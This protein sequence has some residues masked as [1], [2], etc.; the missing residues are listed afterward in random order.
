MCWNM[1][2]WH[3]HHVRNWHIVSIIWKGLGMEE[4][5]IPWDNIRN[6]KW[7][8]CIICNWEQGFLNYMVWDPTC[9]LSMWEVGRVMSKHLCFLI[10]FVWRRYISHLSLKLKKLK[11]LWVRV[12]FPVYCSRTTRRGCS[13]NILLYLLLV[14]D[15]AVTMLGGKA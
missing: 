13:I 10:W 14:F 15:L 9:A 4:N 12:L 5:V 7:D 11:N 1:I 3:G 6:Q 8:I 2:D